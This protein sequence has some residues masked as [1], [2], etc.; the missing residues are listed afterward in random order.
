M[1]IEGVW[2]AALYDAIQGRML[3]HKH[4]GRLQDRVQDSSQ[5]VNRRY[6]LAA[7]G[8]AEAACIHAL[9][10]DA[11]VKVAL[12]AK[13]YVEP[14]VALAE[15]LTIHHEFEFV[16]TAAGR[17]QDIHVDIPPKFLS[18][19][20][21]LPEAPVNARDEEL[22]AT[23]LYDRTLAPHHTAKYRANSVCVFAPHFH[24]Y[25]GFAST[26]DR[27]VLVM[28]YISQ[29]AQSEW[30]KR[31]ADEPPYISLKAAIQDKLTAHPLLEYGRDRGRLLEERDRCLVNAPK[32]RV[33]R[34]DQGPPA[35][36]SEEAPARG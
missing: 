28:F 33:M 21:Y 18:F 12:L 19:V 26:I 15:S 9:F 22:N 13:F 31:S 32:G 36:P 35:P 4:G 27:N 11:A 24:S 7:G 2:P 17:F 30:A 20:F 6:S 3:H 10:S 16:Y 8:D 5:F 1:F 23:I 25:H 14:T 29:A 34:N